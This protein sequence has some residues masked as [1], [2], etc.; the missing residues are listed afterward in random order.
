MEDNKPFEFIDPGIL[1]DGDLELVLTTKTPRDSTR[2]WLPSYSFDMRVNGE[3]AGGI[4][5]RLGNTRNIIMYCGHVGYIV[6]PDYRGHHYAERACRLLFPLMKAH[7]FDAIW[8]T[9]NP[10]NIPSRRTCERLGGELVEIVRIPQ[11]S[12][13]YR[14]GQRQK[15]RYRI[16]LP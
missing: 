9:C 7:G 5:F 15:C 2:D 16:S 3:R 14:D 11:D 12:E 1:T 6:E 10:D 8:I 4:N 13:M